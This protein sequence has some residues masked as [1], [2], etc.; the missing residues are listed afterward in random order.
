MPEFLDAETRAAYTT[1][2]SGIVIL[3]TVELW[4]PSFEAPARLIANSEVD[5][6]LTLEASAPFNPSTSVLFQAV[7]FS[8]TEPGY[9]DDGPTPA[10]AAISN[11]SG[12][13]GNLMKLT[14]TGSDPVTVIYR[15]FRSNGLTTP[16]GIIDG[17]ELNRVRIKARTA[18]ADL[19]FPDVATQNFPRR[20][21]DLEFYGAI[22]AQ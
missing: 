4:H 3:H 21:Y 14:R 16:G 5:M 17:L 6:N 12:N 19:T 11:A 15:T 22:H 9:G 20:V 2:N 8:F 7:P 10:R 13:I 1:A 18:E